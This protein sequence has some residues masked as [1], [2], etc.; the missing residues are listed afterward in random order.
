[1]KHRFTPTF[2]VLGLSTVFLGAGCRQILD[3]PEPVACGSDDACTT[4]DSPCIA[5]ECVDGFCAYSFK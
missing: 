2:L 3:I 5:G 4:A 1:M